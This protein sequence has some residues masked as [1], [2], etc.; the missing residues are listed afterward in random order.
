MNIAIIG[1][2]N[3]A[4]KY[5]NA[6]SN[7]DKINVT[8][9]CDV[10]KDKQSKFS[11][12]FLK[13]KTTSNYKDIP[14]NQIDIVFVLTPV[15][16]HKEITSY[17]LKNKKRVY[18]EKPATSS[19]DEYYELVMLSKRTQTPFYVILHWQYGN[20]TLYLLKNK[21]YFDFFDSITVSIDDPYYKN[22]KIVD[23]KEYLGGAWLDS[24]INALSFLVKFID[25]KKLKLIKTSQKRDPKSGLDIYHKRTYDYKGKEINIKIHWDRNKN[26]KETCICNENEKIIINHSKQ[27]V[28][29]N[30]EVVFDGETSDRLETHYN[31]F[32]DS[33]SKQ[34]NDISKQRDLHLK[35]YKE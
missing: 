22:G 14:L 25:I 8:W 26:H 9:L 13:A 7:S 29:K 16:T 28:Y 35:V 1:L 21:Q 10:E 24:G 27:T 32:I 4:Q 2:G 19:M 20:E 31:N 23:K 11:N 17:F 30:D 15:S 12:H 34:S 33:L 5:R 6:L 3:I 18:L